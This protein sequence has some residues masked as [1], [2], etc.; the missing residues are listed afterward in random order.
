M[1][2][3]HVKILRRFHIMGPWHAAHFLNN[4]F[5]RPRPKKKKGKKT[6]KK[7]KTYKLPTFLPYAHVTTSRPPCTYLVDN[8]YFHP[9]DRRNYITYIV[10][11]KTHTCSYPHAPPAEVPEVHVALS[12]VASRANH[13]P[14]IASNLEGLPTHHRIK[15]GLCVAFKYRLSCTSPCYRSFLP[16]L[17]LFLV[18]LNPVRDG[19]TLSFFLFCS[20]LSCAL[21][22]VERRTPCSRYNTCHTLT[23][24]TRDSPRASAPPHRTALGAFPLTLSTFTNVLLIAHVRRHASP[25]RLRDVPAKKMSVGACPDPF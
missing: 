16:S 3:G 7:Y 20:K 17:S 12:T 11:S 25:S 1:I 23:G 9:L 18:S 5:A 22:L 19:N 10:P 2:C 4:L 14:P 24:A 21:V 15:C 6:R 13:P 8:K